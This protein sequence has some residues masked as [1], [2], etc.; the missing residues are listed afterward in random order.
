MISGQSCSGKSVI[1]NMIAEMFNKLNETEPE[2]YFKV[3]KL[4]AN[5]KSVPVKNLFGFT[6]LL[7]NEWNDGNIFF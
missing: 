7:T 1:L 4:L 3:R 5:P 2:Q 6:N